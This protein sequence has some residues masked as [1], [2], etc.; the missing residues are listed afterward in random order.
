MTY[1]VTIWDAGGSVPPEL[2]LVRR[3]VQHGHR[4]VVL[5]GPP[6]RPAVEAAG[7]VF[8]PWRDV[9]HRADPADPDPFADVGVSG[10]QVVQ[11]LLD[12]V[13]AGPAKTY[14]REV[15]EAIATHDCE[16]L[17]SSMLML[18]GMAAAEARALPT[19]VMLPNCYLLPTPG[20]PPFGMGWPPPRGA[21]GRAR[22]SGM[23][24]LATRLWD[25][26]LPQLN[27]AR[28]ALGLDPL[29]HLF[30]Q[31]RAAARV[32]VLTS[33]AFDFPARLPGNVHYVGPQ[34][35]DPLWA[36]ER[37]GTPTAPAD[38]VTGLVPPGEEPLV[39]V[40]MSTT[41]MGQAD[42]LRRIVTALN[43]LP[44][45]GLLT[46]GPGVDPHAVPPTERVAVVPA[47]PHTH[48][49][50]HAAAVISHGGHGTVIKALA[51]GLPQL[52]IPL[53]RDQPN[54]AARVAHHGVGLHLRPTASAKAIADA[55]RRLLDDDQ[56]ARRAA[57]LG[58]TVRDDAAH[59][60]ALDHLEALAA[61]DH[62]GQ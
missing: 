23:N 42:L 11:L 34:L 28:H 10:P 14:A 60:N 37:D 18:G 44:V 36:E 33:S 53:G 19:A 58:A 24:A 7:A 21:V 43:R 2:A 16:V 32:L 46:T 62:A 15:A 20:M 26:G 41:D 50:P 49:L 35:D 17:V 25:R 57:T 61:S 1:L 22:I 38:F 39:L 40:G 9:P 27:A 45:R 51:A 31:H 3:L 6:L 47:A 59:S 54:N 55:V 29:R 4:V 48:V 30:D 8:R 56:L 5:A 12:R 13:A 52:V